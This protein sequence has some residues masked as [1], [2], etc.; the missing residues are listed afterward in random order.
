[1]LRDGIGVGL[2]KEMSRRCDATGGSGV[3]RDQDAT[4]WRL[5]KFIIIEVRFL[6]LGALVRQAGLP[7]VAW[8]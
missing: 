1:M 7:M 8:R 3:P 4:S 5:D 2:M 6:K